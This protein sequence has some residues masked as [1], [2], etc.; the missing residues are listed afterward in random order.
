MV[1][2]SLKMVHFL[3]HCEFPGFRL[4]Q[5]VFSRDHSSFHED[6]LAWCTSEQLDCQEE[7]P[8]YHNHKGKPIDMLLKHEEEHQSEVRAV[9]L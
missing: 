1:I 3:S 8:T 9:P 7:D 6:F 4:L 5:N 2:E